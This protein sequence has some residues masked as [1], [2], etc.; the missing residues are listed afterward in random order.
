VVI[1]NSAPHP[2][3]TSLAAFVYQT[4]LERIV[5]GAA[6]PGSRLIIDQIAK[7]LEV[8]LIPVREALARLGAEGLVEYRLNHG[9]RVTPSPTAESYREIFI[10]RLALETGAIRHAPMPIDAEQVQRLRDINEQIG[11][12]RPSRTYRGFHEF[13]DLNDAFHL[14]L[15]ELSRNKTLL[16]LYSKLAY[17]SR[18]TR[19]LEGRGVPDLAQNVR[20]HNKIIGALRQ[21]DLRGAAEAAEQHILSGMQRFLR[22]YDPAQPTPKRTR[23]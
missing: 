20:E 15:V 17:S 10:A 9:Y 14:T 16:D 21:G 19:R 11:R 1:T 13:V 2:R 4:L 8:S 12:L 7:E 18:T 3:P 6:K 22:D 23:G 5:T